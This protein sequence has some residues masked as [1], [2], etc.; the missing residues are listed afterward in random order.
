MGKD[1][2]SMTGF[3]RGEYSDGR[4]KIVVEIKSV[5]HRYLDLGIRLP[6][7]LNPFETVVRNVIKDHMERGKVDVF[8]NYECLAGGDS[9][10]TY[11]KEVAGEYKKYISEIARDFELSD[12]LTGA[13]RLAMMQGVLTLE[14]SESGSEEIEKC[15]E[16]ALKIAC[17][18][19]VRG[20]AAEGEKLRNDLLVKLEQMRGD[21]ARIEERSPV[22]LEEYREKLYDKVKELLGDH[23]VDESRI[24]TE[25]AIFADKVA[26][27]EEIVR[28][29]AHISSMEKELK[30]GGAVGRKL[31]F[32]AQEMNRE[33]NTT[34]SKANDL[35]LS[36]VAIDLKTLI[37]KIREQVQNLE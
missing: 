27:D 34:L 32:I 20:R 23:K 7:R 3:G 19:L 28:L 29:K 14:E 35:T 10:V 37:E 9:V 30:G 31:D 8:V 21:V 12:D 25:V 2:F 36:D 1:I 16:E 22:I 13:A 33:A 15:M 26:V 4:Y 6:R 17:K 24:L 18:E 5:N 11:N